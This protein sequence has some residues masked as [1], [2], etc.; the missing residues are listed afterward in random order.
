MTDGEEAVR[1]LEEASTRRRRNCRATFVE[2]LETLFKDFIETDVEPMWRDLVQSEPWLADDMLHCLHQLVSRPPADLVVMLRE[3]G[4]VILWNED[5][6]QEY[7]FE[8]YVGW[9]RAWDVRLRAV[10]DELTL[11]GSG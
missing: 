11:G 10:W 6:T 8:E 4:G 7:S 2:F 1:R 9:L 3:H 5:F